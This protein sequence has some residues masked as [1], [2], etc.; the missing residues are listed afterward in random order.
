MKNT[1]AL[2]EKIQKCNLQ[3]KDKKALLKILQTNEPDHSKFIETL[4]KILSVG[5]KI[6]DLFDVDIGEIL[7]KI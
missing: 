1:D 6:T 3:K 5:S 4:L 2:I 7:D